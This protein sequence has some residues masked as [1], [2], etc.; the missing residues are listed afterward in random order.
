[1]T[2]EDGKLNLNKASPEQIDALIQAV[3]VDPEQ[4]PQLRDAIVRWGSG[5]ERF[6]DSLLAKGG[7]TSL[8]EL[9][10]VP[11]LPGDVVERLEPAL[12]LWATSGP[13]LAHAPAVV[14]VAMTGAG[15]EASEAYVTDVRAMDPEN[16]GLPAVP[17]N[18]GSAQSF[19]PSSGTVTIVSTATM[20]DAL[21]VRI[22]ATVALQNA[23]GDQRAYRVLRWVEMAAEEKPADG[24]PAPA[25]VPAS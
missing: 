22:Q 4:M 18:V 8:E 9:R 17:G 5:G 11:G 7:F 23:P 3:G 6:S 2:D 14:V 21:A 19:V 25:S 20:S 16:G 10:R 12:T 1:V 15:R 24:R 13:N